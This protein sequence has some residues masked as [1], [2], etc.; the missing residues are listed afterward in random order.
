MTAGRH[1]Y[2]RDP[3]IGVAVACGL[4]GG[5][6]LV[7]AVGSVIA[8]TVAPAAAEPFPTAARTP[9][10]VVV[11]SIGAEG[12]WDGG[13]VSRSER[14]MVTADAV[15]TWATREPLSAPPPSIQGVSGHT[16]TS[17]VTGRSW[18][19]YSRRNG[20]PSADHHTDSDTEHTASHHHADDDGTDQHP[21][22][23]TH[24]RADTDHHAA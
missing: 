18:T 10:P 1:A 20:H 4:V 14:V 13:D 12:A 19:P 24:R 23:H 11:P 7:F 15:T 2:R 9:G 16:P 17:T 6:G 21:E 8:P 5:L 3:A 22:P